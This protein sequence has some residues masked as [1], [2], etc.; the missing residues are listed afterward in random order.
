MMCIL[1]AV[2]LLLMLQAR[3]IV[4]RMQNRYLAEAWMQWCD[5]VGEQRW[6]RLVLQRAL[7]R[8]RK[9][10]MAAAFAAMLEAVENRK[11]LERMLRAVLQR[12]KNR[13]L[14]SALNGWKDALTWMQAERD[15]ARKV[16]T[17]II[18]IGRLLTLP[19]YCP[20]MCHGI[21][22]R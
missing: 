1:S 8:W 17:S 14:S 12:M 6:F 21:N 2:A 19:E 9:S 15:L 10:A 5:M 16:L 20:S 22:F 3:I 7:A 18:T 13:L 4:K 11:H